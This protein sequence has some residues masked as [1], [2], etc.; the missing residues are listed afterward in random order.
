[1][2]LLDLYPTK[3]IKSLE[4]RVGHVLP[5]G[6]TLEVDGGVNFSIFS[7]EAKGC[8]LVLYRHGQ[9]EPWIEIPFPEEFR[10][11]NVYTM[12]VYGIKIETTEY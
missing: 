6:A 5:F 3:K 10:I 8:T 4:Y 9:K 7:K 2:Y 11:G 12:I 1:M